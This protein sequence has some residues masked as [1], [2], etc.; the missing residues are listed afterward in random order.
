MDAAPDWDVAAWCDAHAS[1]APD[2]LLVLA[3][4]VDDAGCVNASVGRRLDA[5]AELYRR[6]GGRLSIIANG[7]GACLQRA[8]H[9]SCLRVRSAHPDRYQLAQALRT[10]RAGATRRASPCPRRR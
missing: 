9:R 8:C 1:P 5:A 6:S 3:G 4:G 2:C 7:G 10:S